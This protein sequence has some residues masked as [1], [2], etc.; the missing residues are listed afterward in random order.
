VGWKTDEGRLTSKLQCRV[1]GEALSAKTDIRLSRL[2]LVRAAEQDKAQARMG[3]PLGMI[4]SLMKNKQGDINLSLPVRGTLS[5]PRFDLGET[6]WSAVRTV[7]VHA[8]ALPV[9]WI[10]RVRVSKDSRIERIDVDPVTFEAATP[11]LTAEGQAQ[12]ARLA[13]FLDELPEVRVALTPV[14]SSSD[15]AELKRRAAEAALERV[16]RQHQLSRDAAA[17]RLFRERFPDRPAPATPATALGALLE[18]AEVA[19]TEVTRLGTQRLETVRDT[20]TR[21]GVQGERLTER[22][23]VQREGRESQVD[24][25]ILDPETPRPSKMREV[26]R[27]LG[28]PGKESAQ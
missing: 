20:L 27:R 12:V 25:D 7:A 13:A 26:L 21:A 9:S 28:L 4:T 19:P 16:A 23:L 17:A 24:V 5:D 10:G 1:D 3:L 22:K 8:I 2:H 11:T 6:I 14:A 15:V 18:A